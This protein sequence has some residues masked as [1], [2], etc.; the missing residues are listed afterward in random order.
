MVLDGHS[1]PVL[2]PGFWSDAG[3]DWV[4]GP[5]GGVKRVRLNRKTPAHLV[6]HS[7]LRFQSRPQV[8][9]RLKIRQHPGF[10]LPDAKA[11]RVH[12]S[13]EEHA[14]D[15]DREGINWLRPLGACAGPLLQAVHEA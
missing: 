13:G 15:M 2:V 3:V 12:Q 4:G 14:L 5:G 6:K 1:G 11:R 9:K 8:W 10:G 7:I